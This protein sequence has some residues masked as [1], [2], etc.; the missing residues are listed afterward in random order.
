MDFEKFFNSHM[1]KYI[2]KLE[3]IKLNKFDT[4]WKMNE[5]LSPAGLASQFLNISSSSSVWFTDWLKSVI[6]FCNIFFRWWDKFSR[7]C[8]EALGRHLFQPKNVCWY[9]MIMY[10]YL[11]CCIRTI[12]RATSVMITDTDNDQLNYWKIQWLRWDSNRRPSGY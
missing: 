7:V 2:D 6:H 5:I 1:L 11:Q 9:Q 3:V 10:C 4:S 12:L 8:E